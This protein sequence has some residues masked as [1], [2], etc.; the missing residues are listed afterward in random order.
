MADP[1]AD[2]QDALEAVD[3]LQGDMDQD[4]DPGPAALKRLRVR[5]KGLIAALAPVAEL[6]G[7]VAAFE[8]ILHHL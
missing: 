5:L 3:L 1:T 6:I 8:E 4:P 2:Q 7:G